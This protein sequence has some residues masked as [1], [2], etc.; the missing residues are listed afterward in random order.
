MTVLAAGF[1]AAFSYAV[2]LGVSSA[3]LTLNVRRAKVDKGVIAEALFRMISECPQSDRIQIILAVPKSCMAVYP[4]GKVTAEAER[5]IQRELKALRENGSN[6]SKYNLRRYQVSEQHTEL[7]P[8][9]L[10]PERGNEYPDDP[11]RFLED[12]SSP[13]FR[14]KLFQL[15]DERNLTDAQVYRRA[16]VDRRLFSKIRCND[17]YYPRKRTILALAVA[18][19]LTLPE[20][21]DLLARAGRAF[22][23]N[24]EFD[25]I[26][27]WFI[28]NRKYDLLEIN[29]VL[30]RHNLP[31]L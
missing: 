1:D 27:I 24:D 28:M 15:I 5:W 30:V 20:T 3:V 19:E 29:M 16:N 12:D 11:L 4:V 21:A 17:K 6:A 25:I 7:G 18:L 23:P 9:G 10:F 13:S 14:L 22:S 31:V 2:K 8:N 26:I